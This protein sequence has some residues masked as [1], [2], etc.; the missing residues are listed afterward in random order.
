MVHGVAGLRG[1][2]R[3]GRLHLLHSG[4]EENPQ[5]AEGKESHRHPL[6]VKELYSDE[7]HHFMGR[8]LS[9][10]SVAPVQHPL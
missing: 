4:S 7:T 8:R 1:A 6:Q 9:D 10:A 3:G 5:E 2:Q